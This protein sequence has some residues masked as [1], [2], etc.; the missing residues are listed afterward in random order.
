MTDYLSDAKPY[1]QISIIN[2]P[3][4]QFGVDLEDLITLQIPTIGIDDD[5]KISKISHTASGTCQEVK[6]TIYMYPQMHGVNTL[7]LR[8]DST[9]SG[10]LD[11]NTL[12]Y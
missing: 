12:G 9:D 4:Y 11:I 2:R 8:L 1:P 10:Y 6:T 5:Y 3:S 7:F